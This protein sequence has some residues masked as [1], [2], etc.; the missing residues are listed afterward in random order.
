[1]LTVAGTTNIPDGAKLRC[2]AYEGRYPKKFESKYAN[3]P[4]IDDWIVVKNGKFT[5]DLVLT[6]YFEGDF[7]KN[8]VLFTIDFTSGASATIQPESIVDYYDGGTLLEAA[9]GDPSFVVPGP[10]ADIDRKWYYYEVF[11]TLDGDSLK[12]EASNDYFGQIEDG[13]SRLERA[14][15]LK[16]K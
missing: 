16:K 3:I 15:L 13:E 2:S 4:D 9:D 1:M 7:T 8:T 11:V 10:I 5:Y 12:V 14:K 6:D